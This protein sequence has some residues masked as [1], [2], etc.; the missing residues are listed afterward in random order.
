MQEPFCIQWEIQSIRRR[1]LRRRR[2]AQEGE[3]G[4][5]EEPHLPQTLAVL[6]EPGMDCIHLLESATF[7][8]HGSFRAHRHTDQE[9]PREARLCAV[10]FVIQRV[11]F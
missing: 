10:R 5:S 11:M 2:G 8:R 4:S 1:S 9:L 6:E 3:G 7:D